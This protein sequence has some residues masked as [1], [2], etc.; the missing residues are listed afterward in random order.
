MNTRVKAII[1]DL[2]GTVAFQTTEVSTIID[3]TFNVLVRDVG[4]VVKQKDYLKAW[5][6]FGNKYQTATKQGIKLLLEGKNS[7]AEKVLRE[8]PF[9]NNIKVILQYLR[10][11]PNPNL[12]ET[13]TFAFQSKWV[14][15]LFVPISSF[16]II[17]YLY[18]K[19]PLTLI[20]NFQ[21]ARLLRNWLSQ[22]GLDVF[23]NGRILISEE[24]GVRKPHP[25]MFELAEDRLKKIASREEILCIGNDPV[26]DIFAP[27][28]LGMQVVL[29]S[30]QKIYDGKHIKKLDELEAFV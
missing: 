15:G 22:K 14:A 24:I 16:R 8:Y 17:Q 27:Q 19:V 30:Q 3:E 6:F 23:F 12:I 2:H 4:S 11:L 26:E 9:D 29:V 10:V 21:D 5:E 28:L 1:F 13:M 18:K 7:E 20:S 25:L